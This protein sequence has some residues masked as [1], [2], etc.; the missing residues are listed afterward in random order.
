VATGK[1]LRRCAGHTATVSEIAY[2]AD[3]KL[4]ASASWDQT[5]KLWDAATGKE[6]PQSAGPGPI[7]RAALSADGKLLVT[8][9]RG[10]DLRLWDP[11][12]G[13]PLARAGLDFAG[14]VTALALSRDG[15]LIAAGNA[16]GDFALWEA[17][18]GKKRFTVEGARIQPG[19]AAAMV[20]LAFLP[21]GQAVAAVRGNAGAGAGIDIYDTTKGKRLPSSLPVDERH[22]TSS[23][24][25]FPPHALVF[26]PD[27]SFC[28][29]CS[30][31]DGVA[32]TDVATGK[33]LRRLNRANE[34]ALDLALSPDG[35]TVATTGRGSAVQLWET[36]TGG[37]RL[38]F[39][40]NK[41]PAW[42]AAFAPDGRLLAV[43]E[44]GGGIRVRQLPAGGELRSFSGHS[45][46]VTA[47]A[48]A[49]GGRLL[50]VSADGTAL[51]WDTSGLKPNATDPPSKI[52]AEAAWAGLA[53]EDA[54][55]AYET[56][57]RLGES[58]AGLRL[59]RDRLKPV[60]TADAKRIERLIVQLDDDEFDKRE[61]ASRE[62]AK[63]GRRAEGALRKAVKAA[64]SAEVV[65]RAGD[66]LKMVEEGA[67]SGEGLRESRALEVLEGL[68]TPEAKKLLEE[69][70]KGAPDA[71]L[72][73]EAKASLERLVK[74]P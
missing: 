25:H 71:A 10:D 63:L 27:G 66:L 46:A 33:V 28:V 3:G 56:I 42:A 41:E 19:P 36:A 14:P 35:R 70:A 69:L 60:D 54:A 20:V 65:R 45:G 68:G 34:T 38:R 43:G 49:T 55:K 24:I 13:K 37:G 6:L 23:T 61:E 39:G 5:V 29:T 50:S 17:A 67:L 4:L 26:G 11:G 64:T 57:A 9:H 52:D 8:G 16:G 59:L 47:L 31:T 21:D 1:E 53:D 12:T 48:F 22:G 58:P 15:K 32:V 18:T 51:V 40:V 74:R 72:T 62:L 7:T 73:R 30:V 44:E 2:S